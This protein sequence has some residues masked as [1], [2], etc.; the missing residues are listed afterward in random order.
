[1]ETTQMTFIKQVEKVR[2]AY[3]NSEMLFSHLKEW[4]SVTCTHMGGTGGHGV[5]WNKP[6]KE[7]QNPMCS[8]SCAETNILVSKSRRDSGH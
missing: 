8:H 1:M 7:K 6:D 5:H 4:H 3:V 2:V